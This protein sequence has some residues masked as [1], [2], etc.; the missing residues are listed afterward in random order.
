[1]ETQK[2][3]GVALCSQDTGKLARHFFNR[4]DSARFPNTKGWAYAVFDYTPAS[5][6]FK[7][8]PAGT[9]AC[10]FVCHTIVAKK[11]YIFTEY[12]KR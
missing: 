4:E 1:M 11:D 9:V 7:P 2:E 12:G 8:D 3:H 5:D 10:G 6:E